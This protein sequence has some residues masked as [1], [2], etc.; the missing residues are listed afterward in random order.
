MNDPSTT[1][2]VR[3]RR[4]NVPRL[5]DAR[6][7]AWPVGLLLL[8][9]S[10]GAW[11]ADAGDAPRSAA[12]RTAELSPRAFG[13]LRLEVPRTWVTLERADEHV[14][15]GAAGRDHLVTLSS[16][17]AA[18]DPLLAVVHALARESVQSIP[19]ARV[20]AG[21]TVVEPV[22]GLPR[23]DAFVVVELELAADGNAPLRV[24]QAWRR[25]ARAGIDVV[26]TWTSSDGRWPVDPRTSVPRVDSAP[27]R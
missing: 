4:R 25:D 8:L 13:G 1:P 17:E 11:Q 16:T 27:A 23:G 5:L 3:R 22:G 26:A 19:D 7:T 12:A 2:H 15:W 24:V 18:A 9:V 21:P 14:T 20:V 6:T 10:I